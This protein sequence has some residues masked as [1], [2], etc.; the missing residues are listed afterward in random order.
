MEILHTFCPKVEHHRRRS[1]DHLEALHHRAREAW[2]AGAADPGEHHGG[3][4]HRVY[5]RRTG[6]AGTERGG[7]RARPLARIFR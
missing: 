2:A 5:P 3:S 6:K 4:T 1:T 7:A